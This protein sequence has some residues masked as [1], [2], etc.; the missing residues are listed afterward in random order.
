ML[1]CIIYVGIKH[2]G[3]ENMNLAETVVYNLLDD[4]KNKRSTIY[5]YSYYSSPRLFHTLN[6]NGF[7]CIGTLQMNRKNIC[8][9]IKKKID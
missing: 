7:I 3:R 8:Q 5:M 2:N 1:N 4:Y 6:H 9:E